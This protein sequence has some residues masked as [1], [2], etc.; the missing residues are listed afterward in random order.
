MS[1]NIHRPRQVVGMIYVLVYIAILVTYAFILR[2]SSWTIAPKFTLMVIL[3]FILSLAVKVTML[4]NRA[5]ELLNL[6][7]LVAVMTIAFFYVPQPPHLK[8]GFSSIENFCFYLN[9]VGGSACDF[10][11]FLYEGAAKRPAD[12]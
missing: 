6:A 7:A 2:D 4:M 10:F 11:D 9:I 12:T 8:T 5:F 3:W 1:L